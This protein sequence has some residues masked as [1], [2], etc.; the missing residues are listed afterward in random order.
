MFPPADCQRLSVASGP[1]AAPVEKLATQIPI[2]VVRSLSSTNMLRIN[3]NVDGASVSAA[4]PSNAREKMKVSA[5]LEN[6]ASRETRPN[7][8]APMSNSLRLPIRSPSVPI[9]I[10]DPA[11]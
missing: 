1:T 8:A 9:V 4:T 5:F 7:N 10:S 6:A 2:A 3:D 11:N